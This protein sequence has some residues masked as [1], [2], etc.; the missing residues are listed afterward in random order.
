MKTFLDKIPANFQGKPVDLEASIALDSLENA[1]KCFER[2]KMRLLN[3]PVWHQIAGSLSASFEIEAEANTTIHHLLKKG[4]FVSVNIHSPE[5]VLAGNYD[6][7]RVAEVEEE[8]ITAEEIYFLLT[9]SVAAN[10]HHKKNKVDHF[11]KEGASSTFVIY[12]KEKTVQVLYFGRNE[13]PNNQKENS[14]LENIRNHVVALGAIAGL[15]NVQWEA[16]ING[17]LKPEL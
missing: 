10:P 9:L 6:W 11:F 8:I 4:D 17:L 14:G 13:T 1:K 15:S 5:A 3:P 7:V 16:L 2:A 12:R